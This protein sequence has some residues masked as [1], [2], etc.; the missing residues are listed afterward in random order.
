M[1]CYQISNTGG[2]SALS[3]LD[4]LWPIAIRTAPVSCLRMEGV[5]SPNTRSVMSIIPLDVQ[6]VSNNGGP[7]DLTKGTRQARPNVNTDC[8]PVDFEQHHFDAHLRN[9][10]N[11][12]KKQSAKG[13]RL[14]TDTARRLRPEQPH[15]R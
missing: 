7:P 8:L 15:D 1:V 13:G 2:K 12:A 6:R 3:L 11:T 14:K 5:K 4:T 10:T 9:H